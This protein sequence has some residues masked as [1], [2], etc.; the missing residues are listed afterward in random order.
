MI[1]SYRTRR[2]LRRTGKFLLIAAIVAAI[3]WVLWM[4][5]VARYMVYDRDIG[6]RLDFDLSPIPEGS[7]AVQPTPG[8]GV[9]IIYPDT[10][11]EDSPQEVVKTNISG[12][13][14]DLDEMQDTTKLIQTLDTLPNGTA[15]M[16]DMKS[17]KGYFYYSSDLE[18]AANS[19]NVDVAQINGRFPGDAGRSIPRNGYHWHRWRW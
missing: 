3:L 10:A 1:L 16:L 13:Y 14:I 18:E 9:Q 19:T 11:P 8:P 17:P 15:I 2:N 12:Y 5:W 7:P 6:A 4:I